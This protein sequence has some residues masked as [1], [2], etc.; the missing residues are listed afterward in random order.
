MKTVYKNTFPLCF[1]SK[2]LILIFKKEAFHILDLGSGEISLLIKFKTSFREMV[3]TR[4]P[5]LTRILRR[6][7]RCGIKVSE[8][9]VFFVIR[10]KIY[11][12]DLKKRLIS[13]GFETVDGS[14]PLTFSKIH[15]IDG[16]KDG[17]YFGGY[18]GNP[19]RN[20]ISIYRR[21][22]TDQWEEVYQ[23]PCNT[24]E[25]I[26]NIIADPYKNIVYIFT[27]DF[28]NSAGIWIAEKG[29]KSVL[30]ILVGE[31][32]FRACVG[33]PTPNG[34]VY[35][36]DSPFENNSIRLLK[37][38][39]KE[40]KS[41][42]IMDINGPSIYGCQWGND[43]VFSTSVEDDGRNRSILDKFFGNKR[44]AGIKENYSLIYRGNLE[45]G[46]K[47]LYKAKK[48]WL[49]FYLFQLGVLIFPAG[50]NESSYLPVFHIATK[51]NAMNTILINS[52]KSI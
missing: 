43:F 51:E 34:L 50:L 37:N 47:E 16:F 22:Q 40:W 38:S 8:R 18:K 20:P 30:P 27:G 31:Q 48:D 41:D 25:H 21:I 17:I 36:T 13:E 46:F 49:P 15:G 42:Q 32:K 9:L 26:H 44:G 35:A 28:N 39:E 2:S 29:F 3:L 14:R 24:I 6:G 33:F 11:E 23:F 19:N 10:Q 1:L 4:I 7:V 12:L 5:L 52:I 45:D